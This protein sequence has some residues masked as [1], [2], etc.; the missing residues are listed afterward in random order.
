M[1]IK[2]T[3]KTATILNNPK[4]GTADDSSRITSVT[5]SIIDAINA[6]IARS[7]K[8]KSLWKVLF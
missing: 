3:P 2:D 4:W 1:I 6:K 7:M 8:K 5:S